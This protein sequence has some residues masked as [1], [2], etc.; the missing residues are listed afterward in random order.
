M[1]ITG[2]IAKTKKMRVNNRATYLVFG[3]GSGA[4]A[5]G[6]VAAYAGL[7]HLV[8]PAALRFGVN[9]SQLTHWIEPYRPLFLFGTA[10]LL[11]L[12][13]G[14]T[15]LPSGNHLEDNNPMQVGTLG[16]R[17]LW[18]GVAVYVLALLIPPIATLLVA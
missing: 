18:A 12:G 16:Q 11:F 4:V 8:E 17:A 3:I 5:V 10:G 7:C 13:F 2:V 15:Y 9:L 6:A 1:G 14:L